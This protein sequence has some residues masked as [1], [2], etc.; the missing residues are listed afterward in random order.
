MVGFN[1]CNICQKGNTTGYKGSWLFPRCID[2]NSL[3]PSWVK[4]T[5]GRDTILGLTLANEEGLFRDEMAGGSLGC[6][7]HEIVKLSILRG[8]K[9]ANGRMTTQQALTHSGQI[10]GRIS[11]DVAGKKSGPEQLADFQP[12]SSRTV[13]PNV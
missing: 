11:W 10:L 5:R 3:T 4:E 6:S 13:H 8:R 9:R 2:D 12:P 1:Y 7:D